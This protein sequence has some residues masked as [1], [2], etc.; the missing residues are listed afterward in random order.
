MTLVSSA[1]NSGSDKEFNL[2]GRSLIYFTNNKGSR[3]DPR[4]TSVS[5]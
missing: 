1:N 2:R 5:M 4:G 3:I